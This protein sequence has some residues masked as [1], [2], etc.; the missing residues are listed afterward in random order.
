MNASPLYTKIILRIIFIIC[1]L[2]ISLIGAEAIARWRLPQYNQRFLHF[3]DAGAWKHFTWSPSL[4]WKGRAHF[5]GHFARPEFF[6]E[7]CQNSAG[8]RDE[9]HSL[10][11]KEGKFRVLVLGDSFVYG[12]G[13]NQG[14]VFSEVMKREDSSLEVINA[15]MSGYS[16]DIEYLYLRDEGVLYKPDLVLVAFYLNDVWENNLKTFEDGKWQK[17]FFEWDDHTLTLTNLPI[18]NDLEKFIASSSNEERKVVKDMRPSL[19]FLL[20][21]S[22]LANVIV[23]RLQDIPAAAHILQKAGVLYPFSLSSLEMYLDPLQ[24]E[25][26]RVQWE[27]TAAI[28][29][30]MKELTDSKQIPLE[31]LYIPLREQFDP[32]YKKLASSKGYEVNLPQKTLALLLRQYNV[33]FTD[34]S[35]A[36][37]ANRE[38]ASSLYYRQDPHLNTAGHTALAHAVEEIVKKYKDIHYGSNK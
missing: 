8:F 34:L 36:F 19:F 14:E 4:G 3:Q 5:C 21:H 31:V 24:A 2:L 11:K 13:V 32:E 38:N 29:G 28:F 25:A 16:T 6:H 15:G 35:S 18:P 27:R 10:E 20:S 7:I 17:P 26:V 33:P 1:A 22:V 37:I 23:D 30:L 9:D 12:F